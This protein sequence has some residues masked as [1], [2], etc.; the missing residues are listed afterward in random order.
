MIHNNDTR[1]LESGTGF[2]TGKAHHD[3]TR[4]VA[5]RGNAVNVLFDG[6]KGPNSDRN[7]ALRSGEPVT[8]LV[9]TP[10][11]SAKHIVYGGG[12]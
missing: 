5:E 7:W 9:G 3:S 1:K 4:F 11:G 2:A 6:L 8:H 12:R 10:C